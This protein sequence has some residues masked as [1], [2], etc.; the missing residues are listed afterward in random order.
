MPL[1]RPLPRRRMRWAEFFV[2]FTC[3]HGVRLRMPD[4]PGGGPEEE[5]LEKRLARLVRARVALEAPYALR[6][7]TTSGPAVIDCVFA[8]ENLAD[9]LAREIGAA[10]IEPPWGW[11]T[12]RERVVGGRALRD[13]WREPVAAAAAAAAIPQAPA[14]P[15]PQLPRATGGRGR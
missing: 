12:G 1:V 15:G 10:T 2:Q 11:A 6:R 8:M 9:A 13:L 5:R 4:V 7:S 3:P 14:M